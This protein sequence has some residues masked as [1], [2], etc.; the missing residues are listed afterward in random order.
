LIDVR[1]LTTTVSVTA[2]SNSSGNAEVSVSDT[3]STVT[4][5]GDLTITGN[6]TILGNVATDQIQNGDSAVQ[7]PDPNGN[8]HFD[9]NGL[10]ICGS[11]VQ[12]LERFMIRIEE[13]ERDQTLVIFRSRAVTIINMLLNI[14]DQEMSVMKYIARLVPHS[15]QRLK[16]RLILLTT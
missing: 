5:T 14:V 11:S 6:A 15:I 8:I 13:N 7:I 1:N 2:I 12:L 10:T 16:S 3:S 4:I 9:V